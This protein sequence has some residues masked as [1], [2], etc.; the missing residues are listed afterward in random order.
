MAT[1]HEG[2][3]EGLGLVRSE[4][5]ITKLVTSRKGGEREREKDDPRRGCDPRVAVAQV[6]GSG[7]NSIGRV[8]HLAKARVRDH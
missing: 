1:W 6:D 8:W 5:I 7:T 3:A 2:N 4:A